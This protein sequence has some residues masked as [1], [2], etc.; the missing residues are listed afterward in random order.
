MKEERTT[1][2]ADGLGKQPASNLAN[3]PEAKGRGLA[4]SNQQEKEQVTRPCTTSGG[5]CSRQKIPDYS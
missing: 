4:E 1:S 2:L 5:E 3:N